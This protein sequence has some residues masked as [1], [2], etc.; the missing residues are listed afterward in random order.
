MDWNTY[1][2]SMW[3]STRRPTR[4]LNSSSISRLITN[5]TVS[6]PARRASNME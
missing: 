6:N 3:R 5:T 4:A 1:F 2:T